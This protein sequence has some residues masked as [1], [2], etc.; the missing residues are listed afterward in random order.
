MD[1]SELEPETE[2]SSSAE[3]RPGES[4]TASPGEPSVNCG[5]VG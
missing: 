3:K 2:R 4:P 1:F 5:R